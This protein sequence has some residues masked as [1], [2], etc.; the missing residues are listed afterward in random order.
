M[1]WISFTVV[2]AVAVAVMANVFATLPWI[3]GS[4]YHPLFVVVPYA[5]FL[6]TYAI[7]FI[8]KNRLSDY[9]QGLMTASAVIS[10]ALVLA[11]ILTLKLTNM[12]V[13]VFIGR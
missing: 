13:K 1:N 11:I 7:F 3:P 12:Y 10:I 5:V 2:V 4:W 8:F 6:L 9:Q